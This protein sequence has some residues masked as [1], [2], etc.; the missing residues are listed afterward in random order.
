MNI[1]QVAFLA[2]T[3]PSASPLVATPAKTPDARA[4]APPSGPLHVELPPTA[5]LAGPPTPVATVPEPTAVETPTTAPTTVA[6]PGASPT[7][8][9]TAPAPVEA[10]A[11][12]AA[13]VHPVMATSAYQGQCPGYFSPD[14]TRWWPLII[15]YGW[16]PCTALWVIDRESGGLNVYNYEGSGACGV[17]QLLPC[18]YPE[19]AAMNIARGYQKYVEAGGW[20]PWVVTW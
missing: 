11:Q 20:R 8:A 15:Q 18:E 6:A 13:P 10:E 7:P 3:D 1:R 19:D 12:T 5:I 4:V 17:M 16:D 2:T 14:V 9:T